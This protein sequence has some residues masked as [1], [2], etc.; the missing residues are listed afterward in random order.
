M[1]NTYSQINIQCIFAVKGR[2]Y[3]LTKDIRTELFKYMH[4]ILKNDNTY[5]LAVNG[6]KDH[7]HVFFELSPK[8]SIADHMMKLKS[9]SSKW[10]ND[11][12]FKSREF[13]WQEGY[14]AFSYSK[15]QRSNVINYI[16][17]QEEHHRNVSFRE[18][19][20]GFL[21]KFDVDYD[22]RYLF[23]FY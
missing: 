1:P 15:S 21:E 3:L 16:Q 13:K 19:Y 7:I 23:D 11:H 18:E 6:W 12:Y 17:N 8:M 20:L 2:K 14:G 4:G 10:L 5:P 22:E 9:S